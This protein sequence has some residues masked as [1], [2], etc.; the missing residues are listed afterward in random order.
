MTQ[1]E[2]AQMNQPRMKP[3]GVVN[4]PKAP[5][6]SWRY[7]QAN[8]DSRIIT[9]TEQEEDGWLNTPPPPRPEPRPREAAP[10]S[11]E[12]ALAEELARLQDLLS[13]KDEEL[14]DLKR[15]HQ[16][17]Q[18]EWLRD[19]DTLAAELEALRQARAAGPGRQ[20]KAQ[21]Q[22]QP[23]AAIQNPDE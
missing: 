22:Q 2:F 19:Y 20:Q 1:N 14:A 23:K 11:S 5:Y 3:L 21:P 6:P 13:A 17:Q 8:G 15:K 16:E 18:A 9:C 12:D 7:N 4:T 10:T